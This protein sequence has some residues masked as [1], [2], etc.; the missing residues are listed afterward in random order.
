MG[1]GSLWICRT[2]ALRK[3]K[4]MQDS[5]KIPFTSELNLNQMDQTPD[6][7]EAMRSQNSETVF[8]LVQNGFVAITFLSQKQKCLITK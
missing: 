4:K 7:P 1:N 6:L 8:E 5:E 3:E 2:I